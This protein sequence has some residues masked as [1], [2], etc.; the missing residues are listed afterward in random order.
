MF[1]VSKSAIN[2][3]FQ[4]LGLCP[5]DIRG[6]NYPWTQEEIDY[7]KENW[8]NMT[9]E[10]MWK[11]LGIDKLGFSKSVIQNKRR[12]LGLIG[13]SAIRSKTIRTD[14]YGYKYYID[15]DKKIFTHREKIE[16]V[17]GRPL[18]SKE[19]VHHLDGD[20]SNDDINNLWLCKDNTE[21]QMLHDEL[22]KLAFE[23]Y[24]LGYIKFD[25]EIGHYYLD[26]E[27]RTEGQK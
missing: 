11:N 24:R 26:M 12:S 2:H 23:L 3:K 13:K 18:L 19:I 10:E 20:K 8:I 1:D 7:I 27:T 15:Y 16:K 14:N 21:H 25:K 6:K 4:R 5:Q 9:D 22:E 17:I